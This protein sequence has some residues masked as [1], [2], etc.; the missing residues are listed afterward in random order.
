MLSSLKEFVVNAFQ[1]KETPPLLSPEENTALGN[2]FTDAMYTQVS[3]LKQQGKHDVADA[4][5]AYSAVFLMQD[6]TNF[7]NISNAAF[8][9]ASKKLPRPVDSAT[10]SEAREII[11]SISDNLNNTL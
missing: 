1:T 10:T 4:V 2:A 8:A 7:K 3:A 5:R 6:G 9:A 11:Q